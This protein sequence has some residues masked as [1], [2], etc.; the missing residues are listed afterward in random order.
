MEA[1]EALVERFLF[2]IKIFKQYTRI[3]FIRA[4]GTFWLLTTQHR[5]IR[6]WRNGSLSLSTAEILHMSKYLSCFLSADNI[7]HY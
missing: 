4:L 7:H 2:I 5:A 1:G 3:I 6:F